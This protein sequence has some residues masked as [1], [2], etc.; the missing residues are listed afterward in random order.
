MAAEQDQGSVSQQTRL[1]ERARLELARLHA[2]GGVSLREVWL[3]LADLVANALDVDRVGVWVLVDEGRA[4]RCRY[5]LQRS[6]KDL[7][8][9]AVLRA[10]DFPEYFQALRARRTLP[11]ADAQT[12]GLTRELREAYLQPLGIT[13][14]L[15]APIYL[16]G[17]VVGVVCH[18]H[19]GPQRNWSGAESDFAS[20]VADNIARLYHEHERQNAQTALDAYEQHL[21]ELHRMEAMGRIAAGIAHDFRGVLGAA[22]GYAEL[23]RRIPELP[24]DA[25]R[26]SQRIV[27]V[28]Q[29][30]N[31]MTQEVMNFGKDS[32]VSPRVIE[33][34][35]I[36]TSMGG[37]FRVLLGNRI[38]L[39]LVCQ[40][41]VSRVFIDAMQL[42]RLLL[43]LV[44]NARDA[45][46]DGG[47]LTIATQDAL[48]TAEDGESATFVAI[49]VADTGVG[50][51]TATRENVFKPFFTT[52]GADG[53]G[54]GLAIVE[55]IVLRAGGFIRLESE[56]GKGTTVS[57]YMP[58]IA[59]AA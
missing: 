24:A 37:M 5:L 53:T 9:G 52:K 45:M 57:V 2:S 17:R 58:R 18:E 19:I 30:G 32:P 25:D 39:Q 26:Y 55:Q 42:E 3:K 49:T 8:Q 35:A 48:A 4:I 54:L 11:A 31:A 20:A 28:L 7:F 12:S 27:E 43:N 51:D 33:V 38:K 44:L 56:L 23:I 46:P 36:V 59:A 1:F 6:S 41:A 10:Q 29:R 34:P 40:P 13:S 16:E 14:M 22:M 47:E 21:M 15:D 50:M